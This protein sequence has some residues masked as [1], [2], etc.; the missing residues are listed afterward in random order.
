MS[1]P[2]EAAPAFHDPSTLSLDR[3]FA[4]LLRGPAAPRGADPTLPW[5]ALLATLL[6][7]DLEAKLAWFLEGPVGAPGEPHTIDLT[8]G[9]AP[10]TGLGRIERARKAA[11]VAVQTGCTFVEAEGLVRDVPGA[12]VSELAEMAS[13]D[14]A[15]N[16]GFGATA[17][18]VGA[19]RKK[20]A[21]GVLDFDL[22]ELAEK[23]RVG[24]NK[25]GDRGAIVDAQKFAEMYGIPVLPKPEA[26]DND[27]DQLE[28]LGRVRIGAAPME[29]PALSRQQAV[30]AM[31]GMG[32]PAPVAESLYDGTDR[33]PLHIVRV[34]EPVVTIP[35]GQVLGP[36]GPGQ[37]VMGEPFDVWP[38]MQEL[39]A[40]LTLAGAPVVTVEARKPDLGDVVLYTPP[41]KMGTLYDV[42]QSKNR[43]SQIDPR[44]E[45]PEPVALVADVIRVDP[46]GA[47]S[48]FIKC[49]DNG[50]FGVDRVEVAPEG[51]EPGTEAARGFWSWRPRTGGRAATAACAREPEASRG[52]GAG[53][54]R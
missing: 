25:L 27:A 2:K 17:A 41:A 50:P 53:S 51:A 26:I 19:A 54:G 39:G 49:P 18:A 16:L 37:F 8:K 52:P 10:P 36:A 21:E 29:A 30:E 46:G 44:T 35:S 14:A 38:A 6:G 31:N 22:H 1:E 15:Q 12:S 32:I 23:L 34:G 20:A 4:D 45:Y 47:V 24:A 42:D 40:R 13:N 7:V 28:K 9:A 3:A 33:R 43:L 48:L 11:Q 5:R